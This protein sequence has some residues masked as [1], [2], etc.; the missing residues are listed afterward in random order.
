MVQYNACQKV[1]FRFFRPGASHVKLAGD[2]NYWQHEA[3]PM[4]TV[5][6]GWWRCEL[7]LDPGV[8]QFKYWADGKWFNDYASFGLE[9]GPFGWNSVVVVE[10][11]GVAA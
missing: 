10:P 4:S 3:T 7:S 2:F 6:D 1:E 9:R 5:N 11:T 8:Y